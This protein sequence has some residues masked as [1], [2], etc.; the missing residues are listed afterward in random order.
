MANRG[1]KT[2]VA[3]IMRTEG[4]ETGTKLNEVTDIVTN[5][6]AF[7]YSSDERPSQ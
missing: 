5:A 3:N 4:P 1:N 2:I 6:N 7:M